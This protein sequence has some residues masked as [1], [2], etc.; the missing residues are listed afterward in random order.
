MQI[1]IKSCYRDHLALQRSYDE[2]WFEHGRVLWSPGGCQYDL[3]DMID[4]RHLLNSLPVV[5]AIPCWTTNDKTL[6]DILFWF[7]GVSYM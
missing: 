7:V 1:P 3:N 2:P 6:R 4:R 5:R